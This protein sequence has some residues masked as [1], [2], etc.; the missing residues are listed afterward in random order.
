MAKSIANLSIQLSL[1]ARGVVNGVKV[2]TGAFDKLEKEAKQTSAALL[3]MERVTKSIDTRI[4]RSQP[5]P[6]ALPGCRGR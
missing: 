5:R 4:G 6:S 1:N 3:R 2:T